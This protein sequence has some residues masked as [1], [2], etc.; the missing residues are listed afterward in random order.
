VVRAL[1]LVLLAGCELLVDIPNGKRA[2]DDAGGCGEC[3]APAPVCDPDSATCVECLGDPDCPADRAFCDVVAH[4]CA[5]CASDSQ[6]TASGACLPDGT[7]ADPAR[8]VYVSPAG[9]S[10]NTC[11]LADPCDLDTAAGKL[12][13]GVDVIEMATG[14]YPRTAQLALP[15][16]AILNADAGTTLAAT[17]GIQALSITGASLTIHRLAIDAGGG[18]GVYCM[19]SGKLVAV[20]ARVVNGVVGAIASPCELVLDRTTIAG[21]TF[22]GVLANTG[23]A[24]ITNTYI[25]GNGSS[26][27]SLGGLALQDVAMGRVEFSTI[28]DNQANGDPTGLRCTGTTA[29]TFGSDIVAGNSIDPACVVSH[30]VIDAGYTGTGT[31]N[32]TVDPMFVA[33]ASGD[34]HL[35]PGSPAIGLADPAAVQPVDADDQ[36]RPQPAGSVAEPGAD[37]IP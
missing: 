20:R 24:T 9:T 6:C 34:Y 7:C 32:T 1:I 35:A 31:A 37:E 17:G 5:G 22:Y 13:P 27:M 19:G 16:D 8:V 15:R 33:R 23:P 30:S 29:V 2:G 14:T 36:P 12:A 18:I 21:N 10:A 28:A 4:A 3:T 26:Q 11:G 25:T